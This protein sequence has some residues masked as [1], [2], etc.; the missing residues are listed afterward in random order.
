MHDIT[1]GAGVVKWMDFLMEEYNGSILS[2][3]STCYFVRQERYK[4]MLRDRI[5]NDKKVNQIFLIYKEIQKG[6]VAKSY[7]TNGLLIYGEI[8]ANFLIY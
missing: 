6:V 5:H 3:A 7:M 1:P 2:G 8:F 4:A